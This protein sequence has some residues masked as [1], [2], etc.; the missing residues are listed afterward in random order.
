MDMNLMQTERNKENYSTNYNN[1]INKEKKKENKIP[2]NLAKKRNSLNENTFK[3]KIPSGNTNKN[4][5]S[6]LNNNENKHLGCHKK[7]LSYNP[8]ILNV[9][10]VR[11]KSTKQI[12]HNKNNNN[13]K[14]TVNISNNLVNNQNNKVNNNE[15]NGN[16]NTKK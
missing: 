5:M 14:V 15:N 8:E 16:I 10:P 2:F 1:I 7:T 6:N 13:F 12:A 3:K 4:A 9:Y 11:P